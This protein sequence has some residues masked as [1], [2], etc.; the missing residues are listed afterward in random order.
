MRTFFCLLL[1]NDILIQV[2]G[3]LLGLLEFELG[4]GT[5]FLGFVFLTKDQMRL[6]DAEIAD[7]GR[8]TRYHQIYIFLV[9]AAE[10]AGY[11]SHVMLF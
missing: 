1:P 3:E 5:R 9:S 4:F 6:I 2:G 11:L 7:M 10:G 8:N